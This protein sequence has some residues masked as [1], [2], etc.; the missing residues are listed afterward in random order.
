[1]PKNKG[2][3]GKNFKKGKKKLGAPTDKRDLM[4]NVPG[5]SVYA[6]VTKILGD[7]R[8]EV[9]CMDGQ[10]RIAHIR[11]KFRNK[12]WI[13]R[14]DIILVGLRDF[15]DGKCDVVNKYDA[16]EIRKL[17]FEKEINFTET[18]EKDNQNVDFD[19]DDDIKFDDEE[20]EKKED[21]KIDDI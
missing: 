15:Q 9:F 2:K 12:V 16:S 6:K 19:D 20:D 7:H 18:D 13:N 11:G 14:D 17:K 1:M 8:V 21:L 3:G 5:E 4:R 10:T